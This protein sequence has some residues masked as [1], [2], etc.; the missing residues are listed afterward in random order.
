MR[1]YRWLIAIWATVAVFVVITA[2]RSH[3]VG[4]P[5][6]DPSGSIFRLRF[7]LSLLLFGVLILADAVFRSRR[8]GFSVPKVF[9][10]MRRRWPRERLALALSGLLAYHLIYICYRNLKSWVAF[11]PDQDDAL[12]RFDK[13][14][15]FGNS[16]AVLLHD[17]LGRDVAAH[18]L[19]VIYESFSVM[20]P[21]SFVA[22]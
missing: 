15:F 1:G 19:A 21:V 9:A 14:L 8:G 6:R 22:A 2:I 11:R 20:V 7:A 13:W 12:L 3:Q 4:V 10:E 5:L 18:V 16:P 17:L